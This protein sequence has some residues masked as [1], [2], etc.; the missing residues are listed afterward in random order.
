MQS[1]LLRASYRALAWDGHPETP[2][3]PYH[4]YSG[5]SPLQPGEL[6]K[7]RVGIRPF[8]HAFRAGSRLRLSIDTP[9]GGPATLLWHFDPLPG[10]FPVTIAHDPAHPSAVVLPVVDLPTGVAL[11][12][13]LPSCATTQS[14]PCRQ[15]FTVDRFTDAADTR[16]GD[17]RCVTVGGGCSLRAAI[18]EANALAGRRRRSV[19]PAARTG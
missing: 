9:D 11:R 5:A 14:E 3:L 4:S 7:V 6:T 10:E 16:P 13:G 8:A 12:S 15:A 17:G 18:Q 19:S 1:G 2:L